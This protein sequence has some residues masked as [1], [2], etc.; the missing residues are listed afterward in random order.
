MHRLAEM[1]VLHLKVSV[2]DASTRTGGEVAVASILDGHLVAVRMG[3]D[4]HTGDRRRDS[5]HWYQKWSA[6]ASQV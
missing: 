3:Q 6:P 4:G 2:A 5:A 1:V